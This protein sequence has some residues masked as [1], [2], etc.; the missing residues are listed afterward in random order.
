MNWTKTAKYLRIVILIVL[1]AWVT[2]EAYQHQ[3]LGGGKAPSIHAL[4]PFGALESLYALLFLGTFIKK[5][6]SGTVVLLILTVVLAVL[7][8]RSFCGLLCPFGTLQEVFAKVGQKIFKKRYI[9]P[10]KIDKPLRYLKY[11]ILLLTV[12]MAWYYGTLWMSPYDPYAAYAHLSSV[13]GTIEEEPLAIVGFILL[14][15]TLIGS[16][17]YDRFFC[18]YLCP[19][20][21]FYAIIGKVSPTK[22]ER[23]DDL[24]VHCKSCNKA[25][26]VNIDV[27]NSNKITSTECINCNEC[28][29]SCPKKGALQIKTTKKTVHPL[30]M[31]ILVVGIFFGT[32]AVAQASGNYDVLPEALKSGEIISIT[33]AK[34]YYTIEETA[35]ATG[36][37]I[38]EVYAQLGIADS[39]PKSTKLKDIAFEVPGYNLDEAKAKAGGSESQTEESGEVLKSDNNVP[40]VNINGVKGSMTIREA[41]E[42]LQMDL[43]DFYQLFQI[44]D[45]VPPQTQM[46]GIED[47]APTYDFEKM[48]ESLQ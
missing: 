31:L 7:F 14:A 43:K 30:A 4:C 1:L 22:I 24:C 27:V 6:Y 36:L 21:A 17:F 40:K 47:V 5:I 34:G 12:G 3:V 8:R 23:N 46:R 44:P 2:F 32:I 28:V 39:V 19:A 16:F 9:M 29:L 45:N 10:K 25:C 38:E 35:A 26:P 13:S 33:D 42:F 41:A 37:T 20:G 11:L 15:I 18:K 48:K